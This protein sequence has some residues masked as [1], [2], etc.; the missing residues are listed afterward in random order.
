MVCLLSLLNDE[1]SQALVKIQ[2]TIEG[3]RG[4]YEWFLQ[5]PHLSPYVRH[6]EFWVPIWQ[7]RGG[8]RDIKD[9]S[10]TT[11][12][13]MTVD[14]GG[15]PSVHF[16]A[17]RNLL[18]PVEPI[19]AAYCLSSQKSTLDEIFDCVAD[20]FQSACIMTIE[21]GHCKHPPMIELFRHA[22]IDSSR[23][24]SLPQIQTLVLRGAWNI[25]R[26]AIHFQIIGDAL[27]NLRE[28][29]CAYT[30][31]KS[32]G[33]RAMYDIARRM[34][35]TITRLN[36][37]LDA[38]YSP[39]T[40]STFKSQ[41]IMNTHHLCIA[42]GAILPRFEGVTLSGRF[43]SSLF[44]EA[45]HAASRMREMRL[46]SVD[47][48]IKN[49]C[50]P[51]DQWN[52][53]AGYNNWG[54]ICAFEQ[55]VMAATR[56]LRVYPKLHYLRIRYLDLDAACPLLNP[57][58]HMNRTECT[59]VWN[60]EILANVAHARPQVAPIDLAESF[61]AGSPS[62]PKTAVEYPM[63]RPRSIKIA[64]YGAFAEGALF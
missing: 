24:A 44:V 43:C 25:I 42:L 9:P 49:C 39:K 34:P 6:I 63:R 54:F 64:S 58:F 20:L 38:F 18:Q 55:L 41:D 4:T 27:P 5:H 59:G 40:V 57:Y 14:F 47:L 15:R 23:L 61:G 12:I 51:I 53:G 33:Y 16:G 32:G 31:P 2:G 8:A 19:S 45:F 35:L 62:S 48:V 3:I 13:D 29:H 46:K 26:E 37:C 22:T 52:D 17:P 21:G 1:C 60:D 7:R 56:A 11:L 10:S 30:K 28:W 50:R 36:I